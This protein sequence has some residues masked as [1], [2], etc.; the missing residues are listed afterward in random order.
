MAGGI[1][2]DAILAGPETGT[3]ERG[4]AGALNA[5]NEW[6]FKL[7]AVA[8]VVAAIVL[9]GGVIFSH[10]TKTGVAW[11]DEVTIFLISGAIFMSAA[12]VQ[13]RRGHIGIEVLDHLLP[14]SVN[15]ARRAII[16]ALVLAFC[17][18]FAWKSGALFLEAVHEGQTSQSAWGPPLWIP[19]SVL[20]IGM[21]LLAVQVRLLAASTESADYRPAAVADRR[22]LLCGNAA[23]HV[24]GH[25]D[26]VRARYCRAELHA[27]VHAIS[28]SRYDRPELL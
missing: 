18:I 16:D 3:R 20:T 28:I 12:A 9:T 21:A 17:L 15:N 8:L 26:C 2:H 11:Q 23:G 5:L 7:S 27:A 19:Y 13:S 25:A 10:L 14:A 4:I 1:A 6:M 22:R 24:L